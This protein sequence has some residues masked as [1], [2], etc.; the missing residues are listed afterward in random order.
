MMVYIVIEK[1]EIP[2]ERRNRI[3]NMINNMIFVNVVKCKL[4]NI[5]ITE[6]SRMKMYIIKILYTKLN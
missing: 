5:S 4:L 3:D 6:R 2:N 1:F